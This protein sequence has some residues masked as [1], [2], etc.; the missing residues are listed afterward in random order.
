[1]TRPLDWEGWRREFPGLAVGTYLN[2]VSLG[3]LARRSRDAVNGFMDLWTQWGARAWYEHWLGAV[4]DTRAEFARLIGAEKEEIA[5]PPNVSSALAAISSSLE[6]KERD[7]VTCTELDFPTRVH[8]WL[9]RSKQDV[10]T[11]ILPSHDTIGISMDAY[12][13]AW[14]VRTSLIATSRVCFSTG[15][16]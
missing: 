16:L 13:K 7:Q 9:A 15:Y 12:Q 1:M 2:T 8:H 3:Q 4:D 10:E 11:I 14:S 6:H 5:I